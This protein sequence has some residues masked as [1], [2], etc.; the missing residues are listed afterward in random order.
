MAAQP[1]LGDLVREA[2]NARPIGMFVPPNWIGLGLVGV[3]GLLNPGIWILGAGAELAYLFAL[4]S[5][6]R[7]QRYVAG[8]A[9]AEELR[10]SER[11]MAELIERLEDEDGKRYRHLERRCRSIMEQQALVSRSDVGVAAQGESLG[12]LLWVYLRLLLTRRA[13]EDLIRQS[14]EAEN[15]GEHLAERLKALEL[16]L[17]TESLSEDLR[18]SLVGQAEILRQRLEKRDEATQKLDFLDAE[19]TRI[20]EQVE[21]VREQAALL[22]DPE[23]MSQRID[24]ITATLGGTS[25]WISEQERILGSME[26][27]LVEPPP[28]TVPQREDA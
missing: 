19:L 15:E 17:E 2:F 9:G 5:N 11:R 6:R 3:L 22:T 7:F 14:L 16:R 10:R 24:Q 1:R 25:R 18:K 21:L 8:L 20:E 28:V 23:L 27:L 4:V 13:V 26:D 12:R